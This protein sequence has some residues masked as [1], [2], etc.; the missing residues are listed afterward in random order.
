LEGE[1]PTAS[2]V[3]SQSE[4]DVLLRTVRDST[5]KEEERDEKKRQEKPSSADRM[6][7]P[8]LATSGQS[9]SDSY[10][11]PISSVKRD[12]DE[13]KSCYQSTYHRS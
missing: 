7:R 4:E 12:S 8:T 1:Y 9:K 3:T 10:S 2:M 11:I 5:K 13:E 6:S